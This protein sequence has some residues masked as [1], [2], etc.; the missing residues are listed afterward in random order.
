MSTPTRDPSYDPK[1]EFDAPT[2]RDFTKESPADAK[3]DAWFDLQAHPEMAAFEAQNE[4]SLE[5]FQKGDSTSPVA[6]AETPTVEQVEKPVVEQVEPVAAKKVEPAVSEPQFAPA[7]YEDVARKV[8]FLL[9]SLKENDSDSA[10]KQT[11]PVFSETNSEQEKEH[12]VEESHPQAPEP[13]EEKAEPEVAQSEDPVVQAEIPKVEAKPQP[14]SSAKRVKVAPRITEFSKPF[15]SRTSQRSAARKTTN[16]EDTMPTA[17]RSNSRFSAFKKQQPATARSVSS[18][19]PSAVR[20]RSQA[21]QNAPKSARRVQTA[22][23]APYTKPELTTP[24]SPLLRSKKRSR[25]TALTTVDKELQ[26]INAKREELK[27]LAEIN[28]KKIEAVLMGSSSSTM[29][30]RSTM[31][32]TE[33]KEFSFATATRNTRSRSR[34]VSEEPS[35]AKKR[36]VIHS[37]LTVQKPFN[38]SSSRKSQTGSAGPFVSLQSAVSSFKRSPIRCTKKTRSLTVAKEFSFSSTARKPANILTTEE[39]ELEEMNAIKPFKARAVGENVK[40]M[41]SKAVHRPELTIPVEFNLSTSSRVRTR[42]MDSKPDVVKSF[43]PMTARK[44]ARFTEGRRPVTRSQSARKRPLTEVKPF[45]L[46]TSTRK[47]KAPADEVEPDELFSVFRARPVPDSTSNFKFTPQKARPLTVPQPFR[48][49]TEERGSAKKAK[50]EAKVFNQELAL[51]GKKKFVAQP[52][53]T[54]NSIRASKEYTKPTLTTPEPFNLKSMELSANAKE[55]FE[56]F[57]EEL[58]LKESEQRNSFKAKDVPSATKPFAV[59]RSSKALTEAYNPNLASFQRAAI[60]N[61]FEVDKAQRAKDREKMEKQQAELKQ[62]QD[63]QEIRELRKTMVHKALPIKTHFGKFE[64][65]VS[66]KPL[67]I[68]QSPALAT[69]HRTRSA[70][71]LR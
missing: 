14:K 48:L 3:V 65:R 33:P 56:V 26:A 60:R 53:P 32:L 42:S 16:V 40:P 54:P 5:E 17:K 11:E 70:V 9:E 30:T 27:K 61:E 59:K 69:K 24:F 2:Y 28:S 44:P 49:S 43:A 37:G 46:C 68:A 8:D 64:G 36:K 29:P 7:S 18:K 35:P 13:E 41:R 51:S 63:D 55:K 45:N 20:T 67:T 34:S 66:V 1:Y 38:L 47:R 10:N 71:N 12:K 6:S 57:K 50:F 31:S 15:V 23:K 39:R 22:K 4:V 19:T 25:S 52:L 58:I 62:K 21:A